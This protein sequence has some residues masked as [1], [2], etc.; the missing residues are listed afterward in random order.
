MSLREIDYQEDYRSGYDNIVEDFFH[1]CLSRSQNYW[2]AVGYFS[3]SALESFGAP[4]GEFIRN[5]GHIRLVT[6]VE[7]SQHDLEAIENGAP[8]EG[9]CAQRIQDIIATDFAEGIGN[10]TMRLARLLELG[11]LEMQIAVPKTG[12]GIYHEK[13]G[14]FFDEAD[15]VAFTGS[16]N[17]SRNAFENNREC[18]DVYPSWISLSR[19]PRKKAHFEALWERRDRGVDVY[20]FPDAAKKQLIRV[21]GEWEAGQRQRKKK[22]AVVL[23]KWRHQ[24]DALEE[25]LTAERG[26]LNMATGTGKTRT[27]LKILNA[28][29]ERGSIDTVIVCTNG[30]DLLDQW[31]AEL[32]NVRRHMGARVFRHYGPSHEVEDFA[33]NP[34]DSILLAS[35]EP[36]AAALRQLT[37]AAG[38]RTLLIHDEVHGLGSP[39]N[40]KRLSGL[41]DNIRFR[42]GLSATPE[43]E[44]DEEGNAFLL[45][46]IGPELMRFEL[47][48]AIRR[49]ILAPFDY[50]PLPFELTAN[51]R[52]RLKD[53]YK[54][55][56]A[57]AAEG[58][59]MSQEEVWT[60]LAHVYKTSEAKLP[61]FDEFIA[62]HRHLLKRCIVFV[63]TQEYGDKVLEIIHKYRSDFH[64]YFSGE[65]SAT[66]RRFAR[67]ELECLITCHR[68]S[69]GIDIRSL[70]S[71]ILFSSARARLETIQRM[72]RCLRSDPDNPDKIASIVDFVRHSDED[73]RPTSDEDRAA[74][75]SELSAVRGGENE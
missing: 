13:I 30:T 45:E 35:R 43:R 15:Y 2:R 71:V 11:R 3:S 21:C 12:A 17:E 23:D 70:N 72:G 18:I 5:G 60:A 20:S 7:L 10:G 36:V 44:Y 49:E 9:I 29:H 59:P 66:L 37:P 42:L 40:R 62:R 28:L 14:V 56:A 53:V 55:Q 75:L 19:A 4:L 61:V 32:L 25:F 54:R 27:A 69:E 22:E 41:S 8:K 6:S 73:G 58:N 33:L 50:F 24:N 31:Y 57:R 67:G 63:E 39:V 38:H 68:V 74:W 34:K 65:E 26:V 51:D 47:D 46:H 1:P 48:D 64:T 16:S 52:Q